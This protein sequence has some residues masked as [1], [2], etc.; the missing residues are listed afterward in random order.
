[1][2]KRSSKSGLV[3]WIERTVCLP[4]GLSAEPGRIKL[5]VYLREIAASMTDPAIE[6]LVIQKSARIGFSTLLSSLIAWHLT[7]DAAPV[8]CV[9]PAELDARNYVVALEEIFDGSPSLHGRLPNPS[10]AGRSQRNTLL[11][12]RGEHGASL[13]LVGANAPRNLRAINARVV[14]IDEADA[15][16]DTEGDVIA[17]AEARSLTFPRRLTVIGGTPLLSS[18]SRVARAYGETDM[19]VYE[20]RCPLCRGYAELRWSQFEWPPGELEAIRWRCPHCAGLVA[21]QR[22]QEMVRDGRWCVLR[23]EADPRCRGYRLSALI[24]SLPHATWVKIAAAYEAAQGDDERMQAFTN[25]LLGEAWTEQADEVDDAE[26]QGRVEGF[27]LDHV[28]AAVLAVTIG[29]D[30]ADDRAE[31]SVVGHARDGT[32]FVLAHLTFWGSPTADEDL[33]SEVEALLRQ[34]WRHPS[35]GVLKVDAAVIDAGDGAHMDAVMAFC[36]PRLG[37]KILAGKGV[38]GFGRPMIQASKTKK[39]RL[40]IVGSDV[41][42]TQILTRLARGRSIRFSHTLTATYFEQLSSER[43]IV[44]LTRGRPV[45]RFERKPHAKAESLD[46]LAYAL[47]A[48]AAITLSAAAFEAREQELRGQPQPKPAPSVIRSKFMD[49]G[50]EW[51]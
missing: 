25:L 45:A 9:L 26:L 10:T 50:R 31:L 43:R 39:G 2:V 44:R 21:E 42:K 40:F 16:Q 12:R 7:E 49:R 51:T 32:V 20:C 17:L 1:M 23:P 46:C 28:P 36:G 4:I 29:C 35:G 34:R 19:R 33:W 5:P 13:R 38:S 22:K 11:F 8:L 37:R 3:A 27:D 48:R 18:T 14:L 15:L 41:L 47:A 24:S 6:K 30:L